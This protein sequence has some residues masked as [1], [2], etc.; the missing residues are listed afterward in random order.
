MSKDNQYP[1]VADHGFFPSDYHL[2]TQDFRAHQ[3]F[4]PNKETIGTDEMLMSVLGTPFLGPP[5]REHVTCDLCGADD[6]FFLFEKEGFSYIRCNRCSLVYVTPRLR[7]H[8]QQQ[9]KFYRDETGGDYEAA[10]EQDRRPRR[11]KSL[12]KMARSYLT[13]RRIGAL[14][15]VGCGFGAFLDAA[16][17]VGWKVCG[18]EVA[19]APAS[20]AARCH[21]VFN[22]YLSDTPYGSDSFDVVRLNSVIEH[23][24]SPRALVRDIG[25]VL[26][27]GGLLHISTPNV[28]SFSMVLQGAGWRYVC[29][30][31]HIYLFSPRTLARLM[32]SEGFKIVRVS[33]RGIHFNHKNRRLGAHP[34]FL[35][36][37]TQQGVTYVEKLLNLALQK[38]LRGHRLRV[39]AER[40]A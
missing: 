28:K 29:G 25:R 19:S 36:K 34:L 33:T 11:M 39:W 17:S 1:E 6:P 22:G 20:I 7:D 9:G 31:H 18:L 32:E 4:Y 16:K 13:Y 21:D 24:S 12:I 8:S 23:V 27:P 35:R 10:A 38:T 40:V 26:R 2:P 3:Q 5:R 15:D 37:V 30:Q 14:L